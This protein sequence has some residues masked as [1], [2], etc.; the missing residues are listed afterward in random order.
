MHELQA[1]VGLQLRDRGLAH[2]RVVERLVRHRA[3][4]HQKIRIV[5]QIHLPRHVQ[6]QRVARKNGNLGEH[7]A[8][9]IAAYAC[10]RVDTELI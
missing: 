7:L 3:L 1:E 10:A 8:L 5:L 6:H 2:F 4:H 9:R